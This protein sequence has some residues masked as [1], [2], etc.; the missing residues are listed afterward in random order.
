M[1]NK[2]KTYKRVKLEF[3]YNYKGIVINRVMALNLWELSNSNKTP[4][5]CLTSF[6]KY[7]DYGFLQRINKS[8]VIY[9]DVY[10]KDHSKTFLEIS[11][12]VED[13]YDV[14]NVKL[15]KKKII[16]LKN[17]L[18]SLHVVFE[19]VKS[20]NLS[21]KIV[22][23]AELCMYLNTIDYLNSLTIAKVEIFVAYSVV[24]RSQNLLAQFFRIK[25]AR[26]IGLT[27]GA[28]FVYKKNIPI[29]CVAYE[30]LNAECLVWS[31]MTKE[32]YQRY[33]IKYPIYIAGYPKNVVVKNVLQDN[34]MK[35]CL[36]LLCRKDFDESN[37]HLLKV[38][39]T[40]SKDFVF[41]VKLH[42]TCNFDY[43]GELCE[44]YGFEL[45]PQKTLLT[46][47]MDNRIFD[48]AIAVNTT[49]Y[50]EIQTAGIP[51]LRFDDGDTYDLQN[52]IEEDR[53]SNV[54]EFL[55]SISFIKDKIQKNE[56]NQMVQDSL[57]YNLGIGI[58]NYREI[59]LG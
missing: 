32:E 49:S 34:Q 53:V 37:L 4:W 3:D 9:N 28:Q 26:I 11:S 59:L 57:T 42:P 1:L 22:L 23:A 15:D 14:F 18:L 16:S 47:C 29:D 56:Y 6:I 33:G 39:S 52:G 36:V 48:F 12:K 2:Y 25:G 31:Q 40:C 44:E 30:N 41:S 21:K 38:L 58:D 17:I 8:N 27:H 10:R 35:K 5:G 51:C 46:D 55:N 50:Y 54:E 20:L 24:H 7:Y 43:Y 19:R 13:E 45:I